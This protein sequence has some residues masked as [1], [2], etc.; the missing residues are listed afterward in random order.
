M[1]IV[2]FLGFGAPSAADPGRRAAVS[3]AKALQYDGDNISEDNA[4]MDRIRHM[5]RIYLIS[6]TP[7]A[8]AWRCTSTEVSQIE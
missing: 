5:V 2:Q 7:L 1:F 6:G 8:G 3:S 4:E